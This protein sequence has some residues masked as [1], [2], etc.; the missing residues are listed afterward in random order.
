[1]NGNQD[2]PTF[3][4]NSDQDEKPVITWSPLIL[5]FA[6]ANAV[7]W[8]LVRSFDAWSA[9]QPLVDFV[10]S[11]IPSI[12]GL[13]LMS[14]DATWSKV[15]LLVCGLGVPYYVLKFWRIAA[16]VMPS[17]VNEQGTFRFWLIAIGSLVMDAGFLIGLGPVT[18]PLH[19]VRPADA[20]TPLIKESYL[21]FGIVGI[22][23]TWAFSI[24]LG[25]GIKIIQLRLFSN[26]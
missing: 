16:Y 6:V 21:M 7:A 2:I 18:P 24:L 12:N 9:I 11:V 1:M 4:E 22:G 19:S 8:L 13:S 10:A 17:W 14:P 25:V 3:D 15:Y 20:L 26:K 23:V 5:H